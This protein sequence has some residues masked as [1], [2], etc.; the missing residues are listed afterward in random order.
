MDNLLLDNIEAAAVEAMHFIESRR[1]HHRRSNN[2]GFG[3]RPGGNPRNCESDGPER[4]HGDVHLTHPPWMA[5]CHEQDIAEDD[6]ARDLR[7]ELIHG[8]AQRY[9]RLDRSR[10][11]ARRRAQGPQGSRNCPEATGALVTVHTMHLYSGAEGGI[12]VVNEL[13]R[14]GADLSRVIRCH[15]DGSGED[16]P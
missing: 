10:S 15:Q 13:E 12:R 2:A 9:H 5:D 7:R 8:R 11:A 14:V 3:T 4:N 16:L 6:G 1:A